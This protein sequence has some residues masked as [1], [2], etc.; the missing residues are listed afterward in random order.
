[1]ATR[2]EFDD[3]QWA[4][5]RR[6]QPPKPAEDSDPSAAEPTLKETV[7]DLALT[8]G[9]IVGVFLLLFVCL[10]LLGG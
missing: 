9:G 6:P 3:Y 8:L 7:L 10:H 5:A 2:N 4:A 1:M